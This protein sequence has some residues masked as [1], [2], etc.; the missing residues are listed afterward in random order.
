MQ[1][2]SSKIYSTHLQQQLASKLTTTRATTSCPKQQLAHYLTTFGCQQ[3]SFPQNYLGLPLSSAKLLAAA[4]DTYIDR[5][6]K[7][8]L[9]WQA[10]LLN[11]MGRVVLINSVL[12][13]QATGKITTTISQKR[14]ESFN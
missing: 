5:T 2:E 1:Q 14:L 4:F 8:L 11:T 9:T 10:S 13:S 3:E 6:H 12:D 7:F